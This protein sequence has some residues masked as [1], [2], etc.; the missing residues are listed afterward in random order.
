MQR[1]ALTLFAIALAACPRAFRENYGAAMRAD[2]AHALSERTSLPRKLHATF[3]ACS[4]VLAS[5]VAERFITLAADLRITVRAIR[6]APLFAST[7]IGTLAVA[8]A[9]NTTVFSILHGVVLAPLPY[10]HSEQIIVINGRNANDPIV[11]LSLPD[12]KDA[13][14]RTRTL[15]VM[16]LLSQPLGSTRID[17]K[18]FAIDE[19]QILPGFFR[20]FG[21]PPLLGRYLNDADDRKGAALVTVLAERFWRNHFQA[22]PAIV[23]KTID[24]DDRNA[25]IVGVAPERLSAPD[26]S[27]TSNDLWTALPETQIGSGFTRRSHNFEALARVRPGVSIESARRELQD[28][29]ARISK[30]YPVDDRDYAIDAHPLIDDVV[31]DVRP[32]L[33]AIFAAVS[34]VLLVA[35]ANVSNLMLGR[36]SA[37]ERE[38]AVRL[39]LGAS[40]RRIATQILTETLAY[41]TAG[42]ALGTAGAWYAVKLFVASAPVDVP[43]LND[44]AIDGATLGYTI[45]I[46]LG[47]ALVS[48]IAPVIDLTRRE[49]SAALQTAGRSGDA[50]RGA[51][52]RAAIVVLEVACTLALVVVAGLSVRSFSALTSRPLG[53]D[54]KD[55]TIALRVN[56]MPGPNQAAAR[57]KFFDDAIVRARS[58]PGVV[59][60]AWTSSAPFTDMDLRMAAQI[61][62]TPQHFPIGVQFVGA[63]YFK[64]MRTRVL[65]G[66][67]FTKNDRETTTPVALV[68]DAF[69]RHYFRGRSPLGA[70]LAF[71]RKTPPVIVGVVEST[72]VEYGRA[73]EPL[74]YLP[75]A[76]TLV[77]LATLAVRTRPGAD[78]AKA[79]GDLVPDVDPHLVRPETVTL[80]ELANQSLSRARLTLQTLVFLAVVA[81][82]LAIAGIY[83]VVSY[84]VEQRTHEFGIRMALGAQTA[85]IRREVVL[86]AMVV[87]AIGIALGLV[88][89]GFVTRSLALKL[90][91][92]APL[93]PPTFAAVTLL[94]AGAALAAA[95]VPAWRATR[96]D[97]VVALRYE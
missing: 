82:L 59:D 2:F 19:G 25:T 73:E 35:C 91:D 80:E 96:V 40:R 61:V 43:R 71:S 44:I 12:F 30:D 52:F 93:D 31:G 84:G 64:L 62:G 42:A 45:A 15:E 90:Y 88:L 33:F 79:L 39:A 68:N 57:R 92:V 14:F 11:G 6:K 55:V 16:A 26:V 27:I 63:G 20:I 75:A 74:V 66:R 76:A 56:L 51:R 48:S 46:A 34:G 13:R 3:S 94:I 50:S 41:A 89:A 1:L 17:N 24:V 58:I 69:A 54:P 53:F 95:F 29:F 49:P 85:R 77:P 70:R 37:R 8:I 72:R 32:T 5:A 60:A 18:T 7:V 28:I 22:D 9:A 47:A 65:A 10:P 67:E 78:V 97:P 21:V 36:G 4:D 83:A 87:A 81:F 38:I 86:Q 23:G